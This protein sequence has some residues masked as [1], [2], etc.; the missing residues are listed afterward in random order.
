MR[1]KQNRYIVRLTEAHQHVIEPVLLEVSRPSSGLIN[2]VEVS[3]IDKLRH[4]INRRYETWRQHRLCLYMSHYNTFNSSLEN[5]LL[6]LS[7]SSSS[8]SLE[9]AELDMVSDIDR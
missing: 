9:A 6:V 3:A 1:Q 4:G 2:D 8:D 5:R 7:M